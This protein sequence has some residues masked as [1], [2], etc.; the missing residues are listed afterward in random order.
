MRR[1][2]HLVSKIMLLFMVGFV[3]HDYVT[4]QRDAI[5]ADTSV[6]LYAQHINTNVVTVEHQAF[7]MLALNEQI[8]SPLI[9]ESDSKLHFSYL[10]NFKDRPSN[11]P[12]TPPKTV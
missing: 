11:P 10:L 2:R 6:H 1:I 12:F 8:E 4:G 5:P 9:P 3:M 7:H